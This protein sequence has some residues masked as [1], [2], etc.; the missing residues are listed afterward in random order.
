MAKWPFRTFVDILIVVDGSITTDPA[1]PFGLASVIEE[2]RAT[3]IGCMRFRVD[4]ARRSPGTPGVN[5]S[6]SPVE[7][8]Y[9]NF[10]FDMAVGGVQVIDKYEQVWC[11]G[12]TP[13]NS[14]SSDDG[15]IDGANAT[16]ATNA[17]LNALDGWMTSRKGGVFGTGDHHFLGA[18][19]CRKIPR[20]G[21]M[22]RWTNADGVPPIGGEFDANT[23]QRIDTLRPPSAA[24]EPG[25]ANQG[26]LENTAHQG[27]MTVQ[28]IRWIAESSHFHTI[29]SIHKRPHP[30]LCHPT[31][32]PIDVMP[33][34]AH[35]GL[36]VPAPN[37][38]ANKKWKA[39]KEYPE[40]VGGGNK[41]K[42]KII[43]FGS[44][45]SQPPYKFAKGPQ[46]T[47]TDNPMIAV[48]DGHKAGVGRVAT[49]S[50]W[51]H[52]MDANIDN[53]RAANNTD[54]KKIK[55]YYQNLAVWLNPPG[56][57][58]HCF[59]LAVIASHFE[60]V[61]LQE[62]TRK[63]S[64]ADLGAALRGHLQHSSGPCWV[65]ERIWEILVDIQFI[66][67][68]PPFPEFD[69]RFPEEILDGALLET[70]ILGELVKATFEQADQVRDAVEAER[71]KRVRPLGPPNELFAK[72]FRAGVDTFVVESKRRCGDANDV[73]GKLFG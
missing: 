20:L 2:L 69:E 5:A 63:A 34:H 57:S 46:P 73:I 44:N 53:I 58:T 18:S 47:R 56:Y 36:C 60:V 45:L 38:A 1:N 70:A 29:F 11:F 68:R 32:G 8:K 54:W 6:P 42:P 21:T 24:F 52:W 59:Y 27:D 49:D 31:L 7:P 48:Y 14:G 10:R 37:L 72:A 9:T 16:P 33:D 3:K 66:P 39:D 40:A 65:T 26:K 43:A 25:A 12:Y 19:M 35:E 30:V 67:N 41:P 64:T 62:Y 28:P 4:I 23:A 71:P 50:T 17:E 22:R 51:H 61:G 55:R 13:G 15:L